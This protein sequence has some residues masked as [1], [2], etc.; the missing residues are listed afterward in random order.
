MLKE[1]IF[2]GSLKETNIFFPFES[3]LNNKWK[4]KIGI[5]PDM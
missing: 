3:P 4:T 1:Q 5:I 2:L